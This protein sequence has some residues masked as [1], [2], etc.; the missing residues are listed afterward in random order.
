MLHKQPP[1]TPVSAKSKQQKPGAFTLSEI[2]I[3]LTIYGMLSRTLLTRIVFV[4]AVLITKPAF[5]QE[6]TC[7]Y[8][9]VQEALKERSSPLDSVAITL[10]GEQAKLCYGRPSARGRTMVGGQDPFGQPW[11][12]GANE[13]TTLHLPFAV[14]L[15]SIDLPPGAYSIYAIPRETEWTV[16]LNTNTNRWGIP[17]SPSVRSSDFGSVVVT[18]QES[19]RYTETLTF[20]FQGSDSD[21]LLTFSWERATFDLSISR[22]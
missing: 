4:I 8:R 7:R 17:M 11:R 12:M 15:G 18:P 20:S 9:G 2:D 14:R 10:G 13:P 3:K 1:G 21:G 5:G 19:S 22:R 6:P 16:I